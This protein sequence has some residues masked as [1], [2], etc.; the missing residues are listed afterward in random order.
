LDPDWLQSGSSSLLNPDTDPDPQG[1]RIQITVR[2][3]E[4]TTERW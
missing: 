1:C 4:Y 3:S 2:R